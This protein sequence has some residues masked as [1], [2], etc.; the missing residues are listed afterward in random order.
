[1]DG[2]TLFQLPFD[3]LRFAN[4]V[5]IKIQGQ[6]ELDPK[7]CVPATAYLLG[8]ITLEEAIQMTVNLRGA[9]SEFWIAAL[10]IRFPE[11]KHHE[12]SRLLTDAF[13]AQFEDS[14]A[15][16]MGTIFLSKFIGGFGHGYALTKDMGGNLHLYDAQRNEHLVGRDAILHHI[17][18]VFHRG[19]DP[20]NLE[21]LTFRQSRHEAGMDVDASPAR[22]APVAAFGPRAL[23]AQARDRAAAMEAVGAAPAGRQNFNSLD[24]IYEAPPDWS[25]H[26]EVVDPQPPQNM[27]NYWRNI[28]RGR[29]SSRHRS[30]L[31]TRRAGRSSSSRKRRYSHRR[32]ALRTGKGGYRSTGKHRK[33]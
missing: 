18:T 2:S 14:L 13:F 12:N 31:P 29:R 5:H 9:S 8:I 17:R 10:D 25:A 11:Y 30:S 19:R 28:G 4:V 32:R 6:P 20:N 22:A 21:F 7:N 15:A 16:G 24:G 26:M 1:M 33:V 23:V 27:W 3:E